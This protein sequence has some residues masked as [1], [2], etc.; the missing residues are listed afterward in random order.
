MKTLI[1]SCNTGEGHNS[2]AK[3]IKEV[4]DANDDPCAITDALAFISTGI[5]QFICNWHVRIYRYMPGLFRFG[6]HYSEQHPGVFHQSS[7]VYKLLTSGSERLY[8]YLREG[9]Y[10]QVICVHVFSALMLTDMLKK[11]PMPIKT[12]FV[13]TDY[14]CSPSVEESNLDWYFIPDDSLADDFEYPTVPKSKMVGSGIPIRQM[15]YRRIDKSAAKRGF[16]V[17][18]ERKHL[19]MMCGS[20]GCGPLKRLTKILSC[21]APAECEITIVCGTNQKL[22]KKLTRRYR[23]HPGI[24]V[25]GYVK[26]MSMLMD[27][28]DLYLT[29]PGG[30]SVTEAAVKNLPMVYIDAVAGCEEYNSRYYVN[31]GGAKTGANVRELADACLKLLHNEETR[32]EMVYALQAQGRANAAVCIHSTMND[33]NR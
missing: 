31:L 32:A 4:Y 15:F 24:H 23:K 6:Y 30:L 25:R 19:V 12:A 14:T 22:Q 29:K 5:S 11:H 21:T 17:A 26:D 1:L 20:M 2:C 7:L 13:A 8:Q 33:E 27:S 18:P 16:D 28:A 10:D 3:A 9:E